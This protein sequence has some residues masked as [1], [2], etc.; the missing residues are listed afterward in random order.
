MG[1]DDRLDA[2]IAAAESLGIAI[3]R[4]PLGGEGGGLCLLRGKRVLFVDTLADGATRYE[5]TLA[6][7]APLAELDGCF[8]RPD[9]RED[10]ERT[11]AGSV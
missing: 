3:R 1:W 10:V 4:E 5:R 6:A 2:L 8:L 11:R 9:V 7:L